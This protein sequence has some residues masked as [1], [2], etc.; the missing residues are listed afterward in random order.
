MVRELV[1]N[2]IWST[3]GSF[4]WDG[5]DESKRRWFSALARLEYARMEIYEAAEWEPV[6]PDQFATAE[7]GLHHDNLSNDRR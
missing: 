1:N 2:E 7:L 4:R 3:S 6:P 5:L